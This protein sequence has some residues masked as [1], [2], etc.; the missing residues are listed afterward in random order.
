MVFEVFRGKVGLMRTEERSCIYDEDV[1]KCMKKD[2]L[3]FKID[4]KAAS[5]QKVLDVKNEKEKK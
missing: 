3:S 2:G 4:G 1:L 5:I